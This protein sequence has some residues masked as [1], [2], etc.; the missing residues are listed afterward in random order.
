MSCFKQASPRSQPREP[1]RTTNLLHM[2][3]IIRIE[4]FFTENIAVS[5]LYYIGA[6]VLP[7]GVQQ[8]QLKGVD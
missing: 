5:M 8:S 7:V 2:T 3:S 4:A 1:V 6:A